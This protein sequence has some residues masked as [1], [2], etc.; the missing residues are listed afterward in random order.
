M[1]IVFPL[2]QGFVQSLT[3]CDYNADNSEQITTNKKPVEIQN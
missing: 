1:V 3:A 2:N